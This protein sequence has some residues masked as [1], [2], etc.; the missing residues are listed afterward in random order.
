MI[1]INEYIYDLPE[2]RI[3]KFPL[4]K[5]DDAQLLQYKNG[6]ITH[7]R[8]FNLSTFIEPESTLVF[9]NT[10]V[11]PARLFF[12]KE[13]GASIEI[14]LLLPLSPS[15]LVVE[16]MQ[17]SGKATWVCA[18]GNLK[19]WNAES[20]LR[21]R[22]DDI[23]VKATLRNKEKGF[24][25]FEWPPHLSFAEVISMVGN[26]PLPPYLKREA[27]P[28]DR[29]RYQTIYSQNHGAVAA[30]TAGLHFTDAVF[31]RLEENRI[32]R[33]FVTLHVSAGTFMPVKTT[34]A[35]EHIMHS[36]QI[37]VETGVIKK[38]IESKSKIVVVGTTSMRT[39]E[40]LFWMGMR[41]LNK[42]ENYQLVT[43]HEPYL[44]D[45]H[46]SLN[47]KDA[48]K[49]LYT[50]LLEEEKEL[51]IGE[52]S[53]Y[54]H[55]GYDFKVCDGLITNFHQPGST[56]ML[57]VA[58]FIGEDWKRVYKEALA[59]EYRFLSFGDSSLLWRKQKT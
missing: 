55:P 36:E 53:I 31:N 48:L 21:I 51:L 5:R 12:K 58:A 37:V 20:S 13:T 24:V 27:T 35:L 29:E 30:P 9:N 44:Y 39:L 59:N 42:I 38:L 17:A 8:F 7:D 56:L 49:A 10:R 26:T 3:A 57:L 25:E 50:K 33:E 15:E 54:I 11:I 23:E 32:R 46:E 34:D 40:S 2:E 45:Q 4:P 41:V 43:Q 19:K 22:V 16:A 47:P 1:D 14:F 52:T 28:E 6:I 18:V